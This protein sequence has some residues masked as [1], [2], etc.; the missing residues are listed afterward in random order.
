MP[1]LALEMTGRGH[2]AVPWVRDKGMPFELLM[3]IAAEFARRGPDR[4]M[5]EMHAVGDERTE[6]RPWSCGASGNGC[7]VPAAVDRYSGGSSGRV[8][9]GIRL[10]P[11]LARYAAGNCCGQAIVARER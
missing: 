10:H 8:G 1:A 2:Q 7:A 9:I 5:R 6:P 4:A 3:G 11:R